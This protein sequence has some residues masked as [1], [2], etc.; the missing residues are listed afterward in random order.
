MQRNNSTPCI[1]AGVT[2]QVSPINPSR[3]RALVQAAIE[4]HLPAEQYDKP[5]AAEES[6]RALLTKWAKRLA[7]AA[8]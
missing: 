8:Q 5:I 3:L 4:S 7:G 1:A 2:Y 6:E